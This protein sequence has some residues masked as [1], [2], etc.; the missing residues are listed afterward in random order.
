MPKER[1]QYTPFIYLFFSNDLQ[2][3]SDIKVINAS[4]PFI[5]RPEPTYC[6]PTCMQCVILSEYDDVCLRF[7]E[8]DDYLSKSIFI[9]S[10]IS[11][12]FTALAEAWQIKRSL[13][14]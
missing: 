9:L 3:T 10:C 11:R 8:Q 12:D 1:M 6:Q 7:V 2:P 4:H 13:D 14:Y 5:R